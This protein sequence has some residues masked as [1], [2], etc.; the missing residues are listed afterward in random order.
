MATLVGDTP[1]VA[2]R[3]C[4]RARAGEKDVDLRLSP[5]DALDIAEYLSTLKAPPSSALFPTSGS[6][7]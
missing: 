4:S 1:N 5:E 7:G 6:P 2:A 3:L